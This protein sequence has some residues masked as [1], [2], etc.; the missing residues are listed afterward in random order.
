MGNFID[1]PNKITI[2][3]KWCKLLLHHLHH[4]LGYKLTYFGLPGIRAL[5]VITWIEYLDYVIAIDCGD[6]SKNYN[7]DKA[8]DNLNKLQAILSDFERKDMIS[9]YSL[10]LGFLEE[11]VLKGRDRNFKTFTQNRTVQIYNLDFCNSLAVPIE[12]SDEKGNVSKY[13]K[14]EVIRKLL[15]TQGEICFNNEAGKFLMFITVHT[16]F[17]EK[18]AESHFNA[19][20]QHNEYFKEIENLNPTQKVERLLRYY[21]YDILKDHFKANGFIPDFLPT[22]LYEGAG[23][24]KLM[25][26]TLIG[27]FV[28]NPS[29]TAPFNQQIDSLIKQKFIYPNKGELNVLD[30]IDFERN[31]STNPIDELVNLS[32]YKGLWEK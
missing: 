11:V 32:T 8:K 19:N 26:F 3:E 4:N 12:I 15:S 21:F 10:Y 7:L 14:N 25:C 28:K 1:H 2:R 13:Y 31:I 30:G 16:Y 23:K 18:E 6:Y 27:T 24:N 17:W 20:E 5:D 22:I 9:G 29:A